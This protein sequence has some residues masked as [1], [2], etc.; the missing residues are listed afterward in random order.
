MPNSSWIIFFGCKLK[1]S[2][3]FEK[4]RQFFENDVK[5]LEIT[6]NSWNYG[7]SWKRHWI[8]RI[9]RVS[10]SKFSFVYKQRFVYLHFRLFIYI[11]NV[12]LQNF[13]N[14]V[15]ISDLGLKI[16]IY[17]QTKICLFTFFLL[18]VLIFERILGND[19]KFLE[20]SKFREISRFD[21]KFKFFHIFKDKNFYEILY[22]YIWNI[23]HLYIF[24]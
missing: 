6:W 23:Y 14:F 7:N 12:Y 1:E 10:I 5:F 4:F 11:F 24:I 3:K 19:A 22:I 15:K 18:F 16:F 9:F 20:F 21:F 17:L 2:K 8:L 13:R